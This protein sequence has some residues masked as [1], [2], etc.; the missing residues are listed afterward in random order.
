[1]K[2][3]NSVI[4]IVLVSLAD[5]FCKGTGVS[6]GVQ[7]DMF[8]VDAKDMVVYDLINPKE[9]L[10]KCG[11][12]YLKK[13]ERGVISSISEYMGAV[14]S[15]NFELFKDNLDLFNNSYIFYLKLPFEGIEGALNKLDYDFRDEF[16]SKNCDGV[17]NLDKKLKRRAVKEIIA[18]LKGE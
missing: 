18:T 5:K 1:M 6:L 10:E 12:E 15:I 2:D 14:I 11:L 7:L 17:I 4:N 8:N 16:L 3:F 13:R 9:V